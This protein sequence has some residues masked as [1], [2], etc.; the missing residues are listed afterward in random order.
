[1]DGTVEIELYD[2]AADPAALKRRS[3]T[4]SYDRSAKACSN[5]YCHSSGQEAPAFL[6][7]PGWASGAHLACDGCHSNPPRYD[8]GGPGSATANSHVNLAADG[9]EYGHFLG[10]PGPWHVATNKH[11]GHLTLG[12]DAAAITCQTCH[13][14]TTDP[15]NTGPSGFYYLDTTGD[16]QLPGGASSRTS[17][18]WYARL[19]CTYCHA[20]GNANAPLG[21]GKVLPLRHV[22]GSRDVVFDARTTVPDIA[23]LP[24]APNKPSA[25]YWM[26]GA[27]PTLPWP[28]YAV[29]N[30]TTVSFS[31]GPSAY[32]RTTKTC[33]N[34]ACHLAERPVWGTR[35]SAMLCTTCHPIVH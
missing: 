19:R 8:S 2:A 30:G 11:G 3:P 34:V 18:D 22:N 5:V 29:F 15:S 17:G 12:Q 26:T 21:T 10:I 35:D 14:E 16:Y 7:T 23:W 28:S 1:M 25:P 24:A 32:D 27:N 9:Y 33:S 6:T 31:V 20:S 13:S 4:A